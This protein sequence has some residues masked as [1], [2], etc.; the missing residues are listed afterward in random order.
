MA[1][2]EI[3]TYSGSE[4]D[5]DVYLIY[6]RY[7]EMVLKIDR[8]HVISYFRHHYNLT[9]MPFIGKSFPF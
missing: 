5:R 1:V 6:R 7:F 2:T 3:E 9:I 8:C 4:K